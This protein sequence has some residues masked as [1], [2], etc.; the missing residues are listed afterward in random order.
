MSCCSSGTSEA[1]TLTCSMP[2]TCCM[3]SRMPVRH[4]GG[5]RKHAE[6]RGDAEDDAEHGEE[7]AKLVGPDFLQADEQAEPE[8]HAARA[9]RVP[10]R[11][12][13]A[14][15]VIVDDAAVVDLDAARRFLRDPAVVGDEHDGAPLRAEFAEELENVRA[16]LA[17][18]VAGGLVGKDDLRAVHQ[19]A[20]DGHALHLAAAELQRRILH[21]I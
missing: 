19:R 17:V 20:G 6:Q 21:A 14:V 7:G 3:Y 11:G 16:G 4:A 5:E 9:A 2:P 10:C 13:G 12:R 18:E 15:G 8:I 1:M